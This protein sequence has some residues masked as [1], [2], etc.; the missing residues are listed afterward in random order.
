MKFEDLQ[1]IF[2]TVRSSRSETLKNFEDLADHQ[3]D[4][5]DRP[6]DPADHQEDPADPQEDPADHQEDHA[7]YQEENKLKLSQCEAR[8][9]Y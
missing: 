6:E 5:A 7:D 3:E 4:P 1:K 8:Y 9:S 2:P